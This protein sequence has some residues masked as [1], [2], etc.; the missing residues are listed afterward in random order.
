MRNLIETNTTT[1]L[2]NRQGR[3]GLVIAD[4][5][6]LAVLLRPVYGTGAYLRHAREVTASM[7]CRQQARSAAL[8]C[9]HAKR[10]GLKP[11]RFWHAS[12]RASGCCPAIRN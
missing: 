1:R 3:L 6:S 8:S 10:P 12:R 7:R 5:D 9:Q 4:R 2:G 11:I